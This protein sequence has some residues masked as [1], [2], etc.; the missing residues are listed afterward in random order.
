MKIVAAASDP[1][2][3][4][5]L[6][7]FAASPHELQ[8]LVTAPARP[9]GRGRKEEEPVLV[10]WARER[11]VPVLQPEDINACGDLVPLEPEALAVIAYGQKL[12]PKLLALPRHGCLNLHPS[13]LPKYR[14]A[15]PIP[16]AILSGDDETG[17][18]ILRMVDRM[19]AGP[20]LACSRE[21]IGP[22]DTAETLGERLFAKGADLFK[23]VLDRLEKGPVP[24]IP[25]DEA[26][27]TRAPV[28][29]KEDGRLDWA[30]EASFLER[31]VRAFQPW[32]GAY[33][34]LGGLRIKVWKARAVEGGSGPLVV[35]CARGFLE[36]L[37]VQ[38][39]GK[40]RMPAGEFLKGTRLA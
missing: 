8:A 33:A 6:E 25:Q 5:S 4:P 16:R 36:L 21:P 10:S 17:V 28:L 19:D 27:A 24:G 18:C 2:A 35:P 13:L 12:D 32:P 39:E 20:V 34:V 23:E 37:E 11:G 30:K 1:R 26:K 38:A 29:K 40:R 22:D 9:K 3:I 7:I 15:A 31:Q 14:G